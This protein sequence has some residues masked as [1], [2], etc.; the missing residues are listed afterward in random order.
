LIGAGTV[1]IVPLGTALLAVLARAVLVMPPFAVSS[2]FGVA[3]LGVRIIVLLVE[4]VGLLALTPA[5][6]AKWLPTPPALPAL[7]GRHV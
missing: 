6:I 7:L 2:T 5:V 3:A 4:L 1:A